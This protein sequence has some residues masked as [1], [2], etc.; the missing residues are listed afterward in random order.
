MQAHCIFQSYD[1]S[2]T[3]AIFTLIHLLISLYMNPFV[4]LS[5]HPGSVT[6]SSNA[7]CKYF[8]VTGKWKEKQHD[9]TCV[10]IQS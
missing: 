8:S 7:T 2:L 4:H 10:V 9:N 5:I 1:L 6:Q 3:R